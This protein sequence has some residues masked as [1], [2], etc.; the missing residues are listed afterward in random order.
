MK[1]WSLLIVAAI[2]AALY[3]W[4]AVIFGFL[5]FALGIV[6]GYVGF[7]FTFGTAVSWL[8]IL[9]LF[10]VLAWFVSEDT[11]HPEKDEMWSGAA[12]ATVLL[13]GTIF[14]FANKNLIS[15]EGYSGWQ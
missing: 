11:D 1:F 12:I 5:G 8:F 6:L 13:F 4:G 7:A 15:L 14:S 10:T 2:I 9:V 3:Y